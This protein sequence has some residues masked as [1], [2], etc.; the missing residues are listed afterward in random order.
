MCG[1]KFPKILPAVWL[2]VVAN[3]IALI[4]GVYFNF[5]SRK[6]YE[7]STEYCIFYQLVCD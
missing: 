6:I 1:R 3:I 4:R 5:I 2:C 7:D